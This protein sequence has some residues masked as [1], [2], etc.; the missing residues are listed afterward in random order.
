MSFDDI[1]IV[2]NVED[3]EK[4]ANL[5]VEECFYACIDDGDIQGSIFQDRLNTY[6]GTKI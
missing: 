5:L 1:S 4:F 6:F 3:L 2:I